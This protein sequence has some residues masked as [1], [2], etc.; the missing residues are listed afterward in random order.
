MAARIVTEHTTN[1]STQ[2][3]DQFG[4]FESYWPAFIASRVCQTPCGAA[5]R[6]AI[7][8]SFAAGPAAT[9]LV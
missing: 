6:K 5:H 7:S 1:H 4:R 8:D 9:E 2:I 3:L